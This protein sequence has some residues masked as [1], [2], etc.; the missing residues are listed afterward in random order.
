M[1]GGAGTVLG[2]VLGSLLFSGIGEALRSLPFE[3]TRQIVTASKMMYAVLLI[4]IV[5]YLPG[6]LVSLRLRRAEPA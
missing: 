1:V 6:G 3:N 4:V 2:P 5:T